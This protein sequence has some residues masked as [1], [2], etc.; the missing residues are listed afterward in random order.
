MII[1]WIDV[2]PIQGKERAFSIAQASWRDTA[3]CDGFNGQLGGWHAVNEPVNEGINNKKSDG[4]I[5]ENNKEVNK[6]KSR[7]EQLNGSSQYDP[8]AMILAFWDDVNAINAFMA[9]KHDAIADHNHQ[10]E[11]YQSCH[12]HY[13]QG[14]LQFGLQFESSINDVSREGKSQQA[15]MDF[16]AMD[17]NQVGFIRIADCTLKTDE[18]DLAEHAFFHDQI[19]VWDPVMQ[20]CEGML[21][22]MVARFTK[23]ANRFLVISFWQ[24]EASHRQ[25]MAGA[26]QTAKSQ[27]NL[28]SY[29]DKLAGYQIVIEPQ[30]HIV[31]G[32]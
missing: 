14:E 20:A 8:R 24:N 7:D 32:A 4:K 10:A 1:K 13:L 3:T 25:Y 31:A 5:R 26:F 27:V 6:A 19:H 30:W 15:N 9:G 21:G 17:L 11:T 12:V 18:T 28:A 22:G 2:L 16:N 23:Q 29:I